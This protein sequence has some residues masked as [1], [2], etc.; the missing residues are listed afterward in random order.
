M[1]NDQWTPKIVVKVSFARDPDTG[2]VD[3]LAPFRATDRGG[4]HTGLYE[5][6]PQVLVEMEPDT[7]VAYFEAQWA[8]GRW[9]FGH[10]VPDESW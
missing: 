8:D 4:R 10:R 6:E 7:S 3:H 5:D 2:E 1:P 9:V